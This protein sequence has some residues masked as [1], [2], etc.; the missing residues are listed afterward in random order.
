MLS[1]NSKKLE[2]SSFL[3]HRLVVLILYLPKI[4]KRESISLYIHFLQFYH[5]TTSKFELKRTEGTVGT[6]PSY[7]FLVLRAF[8]F[9]CCPLQK[10]TFRV[11]SNSSFLLPSA[12]NMY[13]RS[14]YFHARAP[15]LCGVLVAKLKALLQKSFNRK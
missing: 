14:L 11:P 12:H 2:N 13:R 9:V 7:Y 15:S 8:L 10:P 4:I 1:V 3:R 5:L 6:V